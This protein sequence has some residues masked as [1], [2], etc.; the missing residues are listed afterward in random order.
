MPYEL[1]YSLSPGYSSD[2]LYC[3]DLQD[4]ARWLDA[5]LARED[6]R[7]LHPGRF[8][9]NDIAPLE[10]LLAEK[11]VATVPG[12]SVTATS[13][14]ALSSPAPQAATLRSC[15]RCKVSF[16]TE[17]QL[18][19]VVLH[20]S[21]PTSL[22]LILVDHMSPRIPTNAVFPDAKHRPTHIPKTFVAMSTLFT[23]PHAL[24]LVP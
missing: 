14:S 22:W 19:Y 16:H 1:D 6:I 7:Q 17:E 8:R 20:R 4:P 13:R 18:S 11:R 23:I 3:T 15:Y 2:E 12:S 24:M 9:E 10:T 21:T 5:A